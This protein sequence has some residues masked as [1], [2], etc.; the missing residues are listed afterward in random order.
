MFFR[1][2]SD[3]NCILGSISVV[4]GTGFEGKRTVVLDF[5]PQWAGPS[6]P[7]LFL[8]MVQAGAPGLEVL[9]QEVTP[10]VSHDFS[11]FP[12][13]VML[14]EEATDLSMGVG[15]SELAVG[16]PL[17][18]IVPRASNY[19]A[20]LEEVNEVM[21]IETKSDISGWVKHR[22]L[23]FS[24][25]VGLSMSRHEKLC[26]ALLQR[27]ES[28]IEA[29]NVQPPREGALVVKIYFA[30]RK[31]VW[32]ILEN[33]LKK[34][35]EIQWS[36]I[37]G[38]RAK[39]MEDKFRLTDNQA[40]TDSYFSSCKCL[41]LFKTSRNYNEFCCC[42]AILRLHYLEFLPGTLDKHYEKL[43][44]CDP[45]LLKLS[46]RP[47]PSL[48][49]PYFHTDCNNGSKEFSLDFYR[50][51]QLPL[52][53]S[54]MHSPFK[55]IQQIQ[56]YEQAHQQ[57]L[58]TTNSTSPTSVMD[59]SPHSDEAIS[60]QGVDDP[61]MAMWYQRMTNS[62]NVLERDQCKGRFLWL[63]QHKFMVGCLAIREALL[64]AIQLNI[65]S[66]DGCKEIE[67]MI[68]GNK[69]NGKQSP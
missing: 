20:E 24:K 4:G 62:A 67:R 10:S 30:K 34:K 45:N 17:Q 31:L 12:R 51:G 57:Y 5:V 8:E 41:I 18:T 11:S 21:S 44:R 53:F 36:D 22:I 26:I 61:R 14:V 6:P 47:F 48:S 13:E 33:A 69:S 35:I 37:I 64:K 46:Q 56:V 60:N 27:L 3:R 32:E 2:S 52:P 15:E 19:L 23:G 7:N 42:N 68:K 40:Q 38:I 66:H 39:I 29:A 43:Q 63:Y 65:N 59:F 50:H 28:E 16:F 1:L 25:L 49:S 58:L 54:S 55:S 9:G